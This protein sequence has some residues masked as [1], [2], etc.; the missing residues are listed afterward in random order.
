MRTDQL[1][2]N[3]MCYTAFPLDRALAG[4]AETGISRVELCS[5]VGSSERGSCEHA[6]PERL[7]PGGSDKL[8]RLLETY[9]L[10]A[11]GFSAHADITTE[12]GLIAFTSRL[13]LA[14]DMN[15]PTIITPS[16]P[17]PERSGPEAQ[18]LFCRNVVRLA[19][20]GAKLGVV[21]CLETLGF[22]AGTGEEW[23]ALLQRL[24]HPN[25]R[26]NYDP[27]GLIHYV[28]GSKPSKDD[29][30][31]L[32]PYLGHVHLNDKA[33]LETGGWDL[34]PVGEGIIDWDSILGELDRVGYA[35]HASIEI[36]WEVAPK[37]P[38]IVDEAVS[39]ARQFVRGYFSEN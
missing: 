9:G 24:K 20:L 22:P 25:L 7:G 23:V 16:P 38:E 29:I 18:D 5:S 17:P 34:R 8:L 33:S 21:V 13:Q 11:V 37:S 1:C 6:A 14:A 27:V 36:G 31:V 32:A 26:I 39:R 4:I 12:S 19:E 35:G 28:G 2:V 30:T 10:T 3:T 15:I